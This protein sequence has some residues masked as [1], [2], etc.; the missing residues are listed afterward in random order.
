MT[1]RN[2]LIGCGALVALGVLL[3]VVLL[4]GVVIGSGGNKQGSG[5]PG[6]TSAESANKPALKNNPEPNNIN[7]VVGENAELRDRT[8]LVNEAE[9]DY[10]PPSRS[11]RRPNPENE[12][13]C[14]YVTLKNTGEQSFDYNPTKF[15]IQDSN[16]VQHRGQAL[17]ELPYP[18][19][20]GTLAP[21][22]TLEGNLIFEVPRGDGGL[23]MVYEPF[24][25]NTETV[26]VSL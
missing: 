4:V 11:A 12:F 24:E 21:G 5:E 1:R 14:A 15:W 23:S 18:I 9:R 26:T 25:K 8:L 13:L 10:S 6:S 2:I 22:G 19:K 7:A 3:F 20:P 17:S 16:G